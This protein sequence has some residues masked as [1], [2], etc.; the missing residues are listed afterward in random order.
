LQ[1]PGHGAPLKDLIAFEQQKGARATCASNKDGFFTKWQEKV[2][3]S[4]SDDFL[5]DF[6]KLTTDEERIIFAWSIRDMHRMIVERFYKKKNGQM[7]AD[8]RTKGNKFFQ[9]KD[10]KQ[11]LVTYS[12]AVMMA[13]HNEG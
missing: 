6:Q 12:Q 9:D 11:A 13:P 5:K 4:I 8:L 3:A 2:E 7:S 1:D 10:N